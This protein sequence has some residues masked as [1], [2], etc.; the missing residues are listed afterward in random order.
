MNAT[1]L[2][3]QRSSK[4]RTTVGEK[5][6][7]RNR[8]TSAAGPLPCAL[9]PTVGPEA[10]RFPATAPH[11]PF[12][13]SVMSPPVI[14]FD[15]RLRLYLG[16]RLDLYYAARKKGSVSAGIYLSP[17]GVSNPAAISAVSSQ[18]LR[19]SSGLAGP[20]S[21]WTAPFRMPVSTASINL[22][23]HGSGCFTV[24][25]AHLFRHYRLGCTCGWKTKNGYE[26]RQKAP[27]T[28]SPHMSR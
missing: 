15:L 18:A 11:L 9:E 12:R 10:V 27:P 21:I 3:A 25:T 16:V 7:A 13:R 2:R 8:L 26:I 24:F 5:S 14:V 22:P 23:E 19:R 28:P 4:S 17:S 20:D 6:F 1:L